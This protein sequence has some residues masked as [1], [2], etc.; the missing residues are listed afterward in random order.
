M[1][2]SVVEIIAGMLFLRYRLQQ[3][4]RRSVRLYPV[5]RKFHAL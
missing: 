1:R 4:F 5:R 3:I 2:C